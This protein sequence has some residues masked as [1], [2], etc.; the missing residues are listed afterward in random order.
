MVH[1]EI[2]CNVPLRAAIKAHTHTTTK[3][4]SLTAISAA[5]VERTWAE[6]VEVKDFSH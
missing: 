1:H 5:S 2:V 4:A 6:V 3:E